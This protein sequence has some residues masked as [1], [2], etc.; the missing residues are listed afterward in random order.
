MQ[1]RTSITNKNQVEED[2]FFE[3]AADSLH[4]VV[5]QMIAATVIH[6]VNATLQEMSEL[7][8]A[9]E[10]FAALNREWSLMLGFAH[11]LQYRSTSSDTPLEAATLQMILTAIGDAPIYAAE[12]KDEYEAYVEDLEEVKELLQGAYGFSD[13][14]LLAW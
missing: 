13:A 2:L 6:H 8:T 4:L 10:N 9:S 14:E 3:V 7:G 1:G 5:E 12:G 11:T